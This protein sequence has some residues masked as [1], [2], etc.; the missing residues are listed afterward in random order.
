MNISARCDY[1][2]RAAVELAKN[3]H[4]GKPLTATLIAEN[5]DIPEKYL[6]HILLQLKRA[7]IVRSGPPPNGLIP[8][9]YFRLPILS[10]FW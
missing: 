7:R 6:V 2:C 8:Q 9:L 3:N 4:T 1:A 10:I 5:R